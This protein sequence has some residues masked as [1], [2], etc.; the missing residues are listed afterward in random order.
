[1]AKAFTIATHN[2]LAGASLVERTLLIVRLPEGEWGFWDEVFSASFPDTFP[3]ITFAGAGSL[4]SIE[5]VTQTARQTVQSLTGVL[6]GLDTPTLSTIGTYNLHAGTVE[7][8]KA[9][10]D[11]ETRTLVAVITVF[12]GFIDRDLIAERPGG[13][14]GQMTSTLALTCESRAIELDRSTH[15][16]RNYTDQLRLSAGDK[17]FEFTNRTGTKPIPWGKQDVSGTGVSGA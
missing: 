17:G 5:D 3:G 2:L 16:R 6:S 14:G 11:E 4:I 12:Q 13:S 1:M 10:Y 7:V 8:A 9:L 15:R